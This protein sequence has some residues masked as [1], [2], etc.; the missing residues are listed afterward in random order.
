MTV[1][2]AGVTPTTPVVQPRLHL[3]SPRALSPGCPAIFIHSDGVE[4]RA[5]AVA[6]LCTDEGIGAVHVVGVKD[7]NKIHRMR[8][9]VEL[10]RQSGGRVEHVLFDAAR[11]SGKNRTSG[12]AD[13]DPSW[14]QAQ[15]EAGVSQAMTDS[16]FVPEDDF[17]TVW[18]ILSQTKAMGVPA[19]AVLPMHLSLVRKHSARL[20]ELINKAGVPVAIMLEHAKDPLGVKA[21][22]QGLVQVLSAE[23]KVLLL[24][25]DLSAIGAV[26]WGAGVGA[27]GTSPGRRHI[28]PP[29]TTAIR[30]ARHI[31]L[32]VPKAMSYRKIATLNLA[33]TRAPEHSEWWTC[34][35]S[36]CH[37]RQLSWIATAE[38]AYLHSV[39]AVADT[40]DEVLG[41]AAT[42]PERRR[43]WIAHCDYSQ[44]VNL[45]IEA[46]LGGG[47]PC[48]DL[49]G[50]WRQAMTPNA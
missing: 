10:H 31:S 37:G 46:V 12:P 24:R 42:L 50:A 47:W 44:N 40:A 43:S 13:L 34:D 3:P 2:T 29:P 41:N 11:Y 27:I 8:R 49:L 33:I 48:P 14:V 17:D 28:F 7:A 1:I 22:V 20:L 25:T 5:Q 21:A 30:T 23:P 36:Y 19:I 35:C 39:A 9:L 45:E 18:S 16:P 26:A 32:F 6:S 15:L 38:E 4:D